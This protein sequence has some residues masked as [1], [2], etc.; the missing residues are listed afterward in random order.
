[1]PHYQETLTENRTETQM[2]FYKV[3]ARPSLLYGSETCLTTKRN[4]IR[5]EAALSKKCYRIHKTGQ[6]KK[7]KHKTK[8]RDLWNTRRMTQIQTKLE[9]PLRKEWTT[10]DCRNTPSTTNLEEEETVDAP[11]NDGKASMPELIK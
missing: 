3:V 10:P 11:G 8:T 1:M 9:Q 4:K 6:N 5:L 7:R 2:K